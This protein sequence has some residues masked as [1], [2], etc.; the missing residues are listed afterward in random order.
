[1]TSGLEN[2]NIN[3][4]RSPECDF[5]DSRKHRKHRKQRP[6]GTEFTIEDFRNEEYYEESSDCERQQLQRQR[7]HPL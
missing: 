4:K 7:M 6:I 1:M 2:S 3:I 5:V